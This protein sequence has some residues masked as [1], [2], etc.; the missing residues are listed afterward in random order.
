M[1][2]NF[3]SKKL[4]L[5]KMKDLNNLIIRLEKGVEKKHNYI[6]TIR[7]P[8]LLI[9]S[10]KDLNEMI[11][12]DNIKESVAKQISY[13]I[14]EKTRGNMNDV[15]LNTVLFGSAGVGKTEISTKLAKIWYS[16]GYLKGRNEP[17]TFNFEQFKPDMIEDQ[18]MFNAFLIVLFIWVIALTWNFYTSYG[19][20]L[21]M[22]LIMTLFIVV[23]VIYYNTSSSSSSKPICKTDKCEYKN[24]VKDQD[25][26]TVVSREGFVGAYIGSSALK[27]KK[28]LEDNLG[29]VLF[30]DEA[31]S[32]M[33]SPEDSF[34]MEALTTLN[35][36]MSQHPNEIIIIF[37]GYKDLLQAG[38]FAAQSG[39]ARRFM[40]QFECLGYTAEELYE[41]FMYKMN[42]K[43]WE[44]KD[45][46]EV[47]RLFE[48]YHHH[49]KNY[50]GDVDKVCFFSC[51]EHADEY[52]ENE[53]I[54]LRTLSSNH[55]Q[56]GIN[57][58]LTNSVADKECKSENSYAN[59]MNMYRNKS[60]ISD[61][62][63]L[64]K[65]RG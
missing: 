4:I 22:V 40:W 62:Q 44:I 58:L 57:R 51:L 36:F 2:I 19:S 11:G 29:K 5:I 42:K 56:K 48:K 9:K 7:D 28:L 53:E 61:L 45:S 39:L 38:P 33:Q 23:F 46:E 27:T 24:T 30:V 13:L 10:L 55:V 20:V 15:M 14:L 8:H 50:G 16:L 3:F 60:S 32:L 18:S 41:I 47:K 49:F 25:I 35:L 6:K 1:D 34:G 54:G 31:Y 52:L 59:Y 43:K 21:T 64:L 63:E 17:Q 26:I 65:A 37:A 12:N